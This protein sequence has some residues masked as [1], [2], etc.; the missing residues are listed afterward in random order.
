MA[1]PFVFSLENPFPGGSTFALI[2]IYKYDDGEWYWR[3]YMD[4]HMGPW[5]SFSVAKADAEQTYQRG[6]HCINNP[7]K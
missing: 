6:W 2:E 5:P 3:D 1:K 7:H 4:H